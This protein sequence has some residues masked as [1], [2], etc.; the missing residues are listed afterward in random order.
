MKFARNVKRPRIASLNVMRKTRNAPCVAPG[1]CVTKIMD[2]LSSKL[3]DNGRHV[4]NNVEEA[5][6]AEA[7]SVLL[8]AIFHVLVIPKRSKIAT[9]THVLRKVVLKMCVQRCYTCSHGKKNSDCTKIETCKKDEETCETKIR[10]DKGEIRKKCEKTKDC[11]PKC[12]AK[13][14]ECTM[15]CTGDL[16]NKDHGR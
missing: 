11:K 4:A 12:D 14:K 15:C 16:C 2:M 1:I 5:S 10:R 3:G 7:D 13:D 9:S 6:A 8:Q